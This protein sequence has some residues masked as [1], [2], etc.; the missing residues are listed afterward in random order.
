MVLMK[1]QPVLGDNASSQLRM[2]ISGAKGRDNRET[3][4]P[5]E[6]EMENLY[7]NPTKSFDVWDSILYSFVRRE[8]NIKLLLNCT[9]MNAE[10]EEGGFPYG[11]NRK[12]IFVTG[13]QMTT[14]AK[15]KVGADFLADCSGD[16]ILAP[17][18]RAE[19]W[20]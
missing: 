2:W 4:I 5:E 13:Y 12:I 14:Q 17:Q 10:V 18:N 19:H 15:I 9:C 3:G 8:K 20:S 7:W 1:E 6:I 16:S 11:R